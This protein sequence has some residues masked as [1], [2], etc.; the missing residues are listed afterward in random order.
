MMTVD[1]GRIYSR[2]H[3]LGGVVRL[4]LRFLGFEFPPVVLHERTDAF[5]TDTAL[6]QHGRV[7][8]ITIIVAVAVFVT[9]ATLFGST[10]FM[11][12]VRGGSRGDEMVATAATNITTH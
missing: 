3:H 8:V 9:L 11:C 5:K 12:P 2:A 7:V 4:R 6:Q 1:S 10:G